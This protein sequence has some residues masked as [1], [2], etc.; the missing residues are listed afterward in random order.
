MQISLFNF[1]KIKS[2]QCFQISESNSFNYN[3]SKNVLNNPKNTIRSIYKKNNSKNYIKNVTMTIPS[4]EK[5][6]DE[7]FKN[8]F[9][10]NYNNS[11]ANFCGLN[12]K[13]FSEIYEK[14]QY[15]PEVNQM[16]DIKLNITKILRFMN[17]YSD[18]KKLRI[19]R[20]FKNNR[21][22][23]IKRKEKSDNLTNIKRQKIF[24][25][26]KN[27]KTINEKDIISLEEDKNSDSEE[28]KE[29]SSN[30]INIIENED[31]IKEKDEHR[32][33]KTLL[34]IKRKIKNI[35]ITKSNINSNKEKIIQKPIDITNI[36]SNS[37]ENEKKDNSFLSNDT[38]KDFNNEFILF[39]S[40]IPFKSYLN[41][42]YILSSDSNKNNIF[43]FSSKAIQN[44][45]Y[46]N[47]QNFEEK[48]NNNNN[49]SP[50]IS[51]N[52]NE[53]PDNKFNSLNSH[54]F[55]IKSPFIMNNIFC[56]I[57]NFNN[58]NQ[59]IDENDENKYNKNIIE[60]IMNQIDSDS[61]NI[62]N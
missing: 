58:E 13:M 34:N 41:N 19:R 1:S 24:L 50:Y 33:E 54:N 9:F 4:N 28:K 52:S 39:S 61:I 14:N 23:K 44:S 45:D 36:T 40:D 15:T 55:L 62:Y 29:S 18:S 7:N 47:Y 35:F 46:F 38:G 27:K 56:E 22:I 51:F 20:R 37:K 60:E 8:D 3:F 10:A 2:E 5:L 17:K 31:D 49:I 48:S 57:F 53:F 42:D 25:I 43:N 26:E 16:G 11:F 21:Q 12:E 59:N 6:K 30:S 32:K